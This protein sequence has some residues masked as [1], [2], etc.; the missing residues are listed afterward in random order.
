MS[1]SYSNNSEAIEVK[2]ESFGGLGDG[3]ATYD[4][5]PVFVAKSVAGDVLRVRVISENS[6]GK[7]AEIVEILQAGEDRR[8]PPC[9][10]FAGCGGCGLQHLQDAAYQEFKN[11]IAYNCLKQA[12]YEK[13]HV[14]VVFMPPDSRRRVDFKVTSHN[15]SWS[16]AYLGGRSHDKVAI[17]NCLI[18]EYELQELIPVINGMLGHISF[19]KDIAE[20]RVT[21]SDT[22]LDL[23]FALDKEI[24]PIVSS[25]SSPLKAELM[26]IADTA[27]LAR[28]SVIGSNNQ[29]VEVE[30]RRRIT[31][32]LGEYDI[33]LPQDSFLQASRKGM[34]LLTK[35][36]KHELRNCKAILDLFC[37][38]GA[39][40]IPLAEAAS[41]HAVDDHEGMVIGLRLAARSYGITLTTE[42]RNLLNRPLAPF[43]LAKFDGVVINPPRAGAKAQ[44]EQIVAAQVKNLVMISCNPATFARDA[45]ILKEAGYELMD[46][47]AIDQF[48]WSPHLE[49][50]ASFLLRS[51]TQVKPQL[52]SSDESW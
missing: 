52:K 17:N 44:I 18:L 19:V 6:E 26:T 48:V 16:L 35:Y 9:P 7:R 34:R 31:V 28:V 43:E 13:Y 10:Y 29:I 2:I 5:K 39:Y 30:E 12:G 24:A 4:G 40:S 22:G 50:A 45:K 49:I 20:V 32:R 27:K 23:V 8:I 46:A 11:K 47:T 41:V 38:V 37:G 36:V 42:K 1:E 15:G 51:P 21:A 25:G 14:N 3:I 33:N